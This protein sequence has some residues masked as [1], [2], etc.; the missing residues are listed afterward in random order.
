MK[1]SGSPENERIKMECY[2]VITAVNDPH[3]EGAG[4]IERVREA[5]A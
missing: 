3:H 1:Y 2:P 4:L 5:S